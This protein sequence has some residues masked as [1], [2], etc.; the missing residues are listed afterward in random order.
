M[1]PRWLAALPPLQLRRGLYRYGC[2]LWSE[3]HYSNI[4]SRFSF[5]FL[6]NLAGA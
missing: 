5:K 6:Q 1:V 4:L 3:M 2:V